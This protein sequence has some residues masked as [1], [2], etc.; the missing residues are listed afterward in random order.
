MF[1]KKKIEVLYLY[2][3][4]DEFVLGNLMMYQEKRLVS[5]DQVKPDDLKELGSKDEAEKSEDEQQPAAED[6]SLLVARFKELLGD[7][8]V[9]VKTSERLVD[10]P[11]CLVSED[12]QLSAHLDRMMRMM[13]KLTDLPKRVLE[14]NPQHPLVGNL[15]RICQRDSRDPFLEL[16]CEQIFEGAML[17]DGYLADPH[18]LVERMNSILADAAA[19]KTG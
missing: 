8:V 9:D 17:M 6:I 7:R 2:E 4:A 18:K 14:L 19:S 12:G 3:A 10:S 5:A 13:N 11:A 16:A 15:T 1:R